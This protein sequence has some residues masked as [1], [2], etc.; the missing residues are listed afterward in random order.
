MKYFDRIL[1]KLRTNQVIRHIPQGSV[2][3]DVGS[4]DGYLF[5]V[6]DDRLKSG[7][8]IDP[9]VENRIEGP[10]FT[11]LKGIFPNDIPTGKKFDIITFI[12]VIEHLLPEQLLKLDETCC[13]LLNENGLVIITVPAPLVDKILDVLLF[14][15][16]IDGMS[17]GEHHGFLPSH[18]PGLFKMNFSAEF[19]KR[20]QLGLNHLF[21]FRKK[22][23]T[24]FSKV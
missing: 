19:H 6:L 11:V 16:V 5:R 20:F 3:L 9:E 7:I 13:S 10:S 17:L 23:Q 14:L 2:I 1:Q 15:K 21:V 18:V 4:S 12:A 22:P 24:Q 8:G